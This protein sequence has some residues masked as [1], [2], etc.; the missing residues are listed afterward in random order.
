MVVYNSLAG[1]SCTPA[2]GITCEIVG[3]AAGLL[4]EHELPPKARIEPT[5]TAT[6]FKRDFV[7]R[8]VEVFNIALRDKKQAS[9]T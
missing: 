4:E 2:A 3:D 7:T 6:R 9:P 1:G 5:M 8:L